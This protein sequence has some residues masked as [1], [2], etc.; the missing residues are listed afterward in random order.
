V[1]ITIKAVNNPPYI[2][3]ANDY[4]YVDPSE[5]SRRLVEMPFTN[6]SV[7][8]FDQFD[9]TGTTSCTYVVENNDERIVSPT[10]FFCTDD[11]EILQMDITLEVDLGTLTITLTSLPAMTAASRKG[12]NEWKHLDQIIE[13]NRTVQMIGQGIKFQASIAD[14]NAALKTLYYSIGPLKVWQ[15]FK[16]FSLDCIDAHAYQVYS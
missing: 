16:L 3:A 10:M 12:Q 2:V 5:V 14:A 7:G 11:N 15:F 9:K 4:L 13:P 6:I 1:N 8:D